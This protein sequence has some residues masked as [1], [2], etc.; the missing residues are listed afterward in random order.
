MAF[1]T[2]STLSDLVEVPGK[3]D[4][5]DFSV[6]N[7]KQPYPDLCMELMNKIIRSSKLIHAAL[8]IFPTEIIYFNSSKQKEDK[9]IVDNL[10]FAILFGKFPI[11]ISPLKMA[12]CELSQVSDEVEQGQDTAQCSD[13]ACRYCYGGDG[14]CLQ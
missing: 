5:Y 8:M 13:T 9:E 4:N 14:H 6:V 7:M 1:E 12:Y 10:E 2:I 11:L 3:L